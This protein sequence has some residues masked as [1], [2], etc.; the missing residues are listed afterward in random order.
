MFK[1]AR[2]GV[3]AAGFLAVGL[4]VIGIAAPAMATSATVGGDL[5]CNGNNV[6]YNTTRY[7]SAN[8][9]RIQYTLQNTAGSADGLDITYLGALQVNGNVYLG[10]KSMSIQSPSAVL[11]GYY[12]KNTAF[13]LYG[14]MPASLG[15]CDNKF[16]GVL[17]Y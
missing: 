17:Y 10:Q 9:T 12:L 11:S 15:A 8:S 16:S 14:H 3:V 7:V 2:R 1:N 5:N 13:K 6:Y 4:S